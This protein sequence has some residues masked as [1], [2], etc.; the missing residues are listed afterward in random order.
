MRK[1][2]SSP[3]GAYSFNHAVI[4][5]QYTL[6]CTTHKMVQFCEWWKYFYLLLYILIIGHSFKLQ[7]LHCNSSFKCTSICSLPGSSADGLQPPKWYDGGLSGVDRRFKCADDSMLTP[8]ALDWEFQKGVYQYCTPKIG[9]VVVWHLM[10]HSAVD[11]CPW[12]SPCTVN[13]VRE[14]SL[15][16]H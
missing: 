8:K 11:V 15:I 7:I 14:P 4:F 9:Q 13:V 16:L 12:P 10:F 3:V 5:V 6:Q 1:T 2:F